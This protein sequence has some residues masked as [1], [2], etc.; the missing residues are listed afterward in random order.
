MN[1][2]L[3]RLLACAVVLGVSAGSTAWGA[4]PQELLATPV[5]PFGVPGF[6]RVLHDS[7]ADELI[8]AVTPQD[9]RSTAFDQ[10][11]ATWEVSTPEGVQTQASP[12]VSLSTF[13]P[14]SET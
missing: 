14:W 13:G 9:L 6:I 11:F 1:R 3:L 12:P 2:Y 7:G 5:D 4:E 10:F 8:L